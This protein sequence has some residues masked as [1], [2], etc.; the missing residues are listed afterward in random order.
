MSRPSASS[1]SV[2]SPYDSVYPP[3]SSNPSSKGSPL[4]N[5]LDRTTNDQAL[6]RRARGESEPEDTDGKTPLAPNMPQPT[7]GFRGAAPALH[8]PA[9]I[10]CLLYSLFMFSFQI[11]FTLGRMLYDLYNQNQNNPERPANPP[12]EHPLASNMTF[13]YNNRNPDTNSSGSTTTNNHT[14]GK[15]SYGKNARNDFRQATFN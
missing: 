8:Y 13:D 14:T 7:E 15:K 9:M 11:I 12:H 5:Q 2:E 10:A 1:S 4:L 6:V 3:E